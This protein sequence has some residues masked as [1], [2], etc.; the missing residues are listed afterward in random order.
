MFIMFVCIYIR[1]YNLKGLMPA[2]IRTHENEIVCSFAKFDRKKYIC[3]YN[4]LLL[5]TTR[6]YC[7]SHRDPASS[8]QS[9]QQCTLKVYELW[10]NRQGGKSTE[11]RWI[12]ISGNIFIDR[13]TCQLDC[14]TLKGS[15][16]THTL[17]KTLD[18]FDNCQRSIVHKTTNL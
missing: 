5:K 1:S 15:G 8:F 11:K 14:D 4:H 7:S 17:L 6:V 18:T 12:I 3:G 10:L 16:V 9:Q 2:L 13:C